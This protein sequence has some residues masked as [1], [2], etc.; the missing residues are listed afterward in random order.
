[1]ASLWLDSEF[2][3][4]ADPKDDLLAASPQ[5]HARAIGGVAHELI[6]IDVKLRHDLRRQSVLPGELGAGGQNSSFGVIEDIII[7]V[8]ERDL[9]R[10]IVGRVL[11]VHNLCARAEGQRP[12]GHLP[13]DVIRS[14]V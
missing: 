6:I 14:E 4:C 3:S 12:I 10:K 9:R 13:P 1:M 11:I 2:I 5:N 8:F 7:V